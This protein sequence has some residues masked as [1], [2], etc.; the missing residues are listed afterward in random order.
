M[1]K[2]AFIINFNKEKWQGGFNVIV[3]LINAILINKKKSKKINIFL[4]VSNKKILINCKIPNSVK[5]IEDKEITKPKQYKRFIDKIFLIFFNKTFFLEKRLKKYGINI[6]SHSNIYTGKKSITKSIVWIPDFQFFHFPNNFSLKYKILKKINLLIYSKY[7]DQILLSSNTAKND[8]KKI[9]YPAFKM[10]LVN[11]FCFP[12]S[13]KMNRSIL[14]K[15][16]KDYKIPNKFFYVPNQY[17]VHKNHKVVLKA[18]K[19]LK[20][21]SKIKI[22]STG[23]SQDYRFPDYFKSIS[24]YINDNKLNNNFIYLGVVP[25][26]IVKYLM[27]KC[28]AIINPSKFEGWNTSVEQGKAI[29]KK[30]I[31][32]NI[33]THKEQNPPDAYFFGVNNYLELAKIL[34]QTWS[35]G[36]NNKS[37]MRKFYSFNDEF[38]NYGEKF[39]K[40]IFNVCE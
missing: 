11:S 14:K 40:I 17:W 3:N 27:H 38:K 39:L 32:S 25:D 34:N 10:A 35:K 4:I 31:L 20:K 9:C 15:I 5:I 12:E 33:S 26:K 6:I 29:G 16:L 22:I 7:S 23:F 36:N 21:N 19:F 8:L 24:K 30:I 18:L 13:K 28:L 1:I 37:V 2:L